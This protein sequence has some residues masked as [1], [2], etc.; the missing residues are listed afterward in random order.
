M[1]QAALQRTRKLLRA[2]IKDLRKEMIMEDDITYR[3]IGCIRTPFRELAGMPIQ[4]PGAR[5]IAGTV[6]MDEA[7]RE[8]LKGL[9]EFSHIF[10]LYHFHLCE[11][12]ALQVKPF[13]GDAEQGIFACRS[14]KRPN[15]IGLSVV[16]LIRIDGLTLHIE[17]VD[18]VDGTP[19]LEIKPYVP[20]FDAA[21][22]AKTGWLSEKAVH[23][24]KARSDG[25]FQ[26]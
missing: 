25:R 14:P 5:G 22:D 1:R 15:P 11:G 16:R 21:A 2:G 4:P 13:L 17:D 10:L 12:Y 23:V 19:L 3:P 7:Y 8:G 18:M 26:K 20:I 9:E 6:V 24:F